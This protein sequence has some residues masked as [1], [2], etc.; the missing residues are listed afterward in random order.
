MS[1]G[2]SVGRITAVAEMLAR[3]L[4]RRRGALA[5]I[6]ALPLAFYGFSR[7]AGPYH[8]TAGGIGTAWA[9]SAAALFAALSGRSVDDRLVLD[10]YRPGELFAGRLV[11]LT[12]FGVVLSAGVGA[13]M[14]GVSGAVDPGAFW[15]AMA[16][17]AGVSV[18]FGL[19]VG[20]VVPR[21]LEG[22]LVLIGVTGI[23]VALPSSSAVVGAFPL[24]GAQRLLD[25][26]SY[27]SFPV[28]P[29]LER[30]LGWIALFGVVAVV[31]W[32]R[33]IGPST[34]RQSW[35][36]WRRTA[37][38][39]ASVLASGLMVLSVTGPAAASGASGQDRRGQRAV[40]AV[41]NQWG[42]CLGFAGVAVQGVSGT[43]A[44]R[45]GRVGLELMVVG[46][47]GPT[48]FVPDAPAVPVASPTN[49][50][51]LALIRKGK[52]ADPGCAGVRP[53]SPEP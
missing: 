35:N 36:P 26:A 46:P 51:A 20:A 7:T 53:A 12:G 21:E 28:A 48:F 32:R 8:L 6:V 38:A 19:A 16:L 22:V 41:I 39:L 14:L 34:L 2:Q 50:A 33:R 10:G 42:N 24:G 40:M 47:G 52:E 4:L 13:L 43:Q 23:Q 15:L 1:P 17:V 29:A 30:S 5:L 27:A 45:G 31:A 25:R 11:T 3:D 44:H 37:P 18:P 49:D 9:I